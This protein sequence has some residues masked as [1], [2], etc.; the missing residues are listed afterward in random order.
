MSSSRIREPV[1]DTEISCFGEIMTAYLGGDERVQSAVF[2]DLLGETID[3]Y[4]CNDLFLT[5]LSAAHYGLVFSS[6]KARIDW[7][8]MGDVEMIEVCTTTVESVTVS[9]GDGYFLTVIASHG[10]VK[11]DFYDLV[12]GVVA[13]LREEAGLNN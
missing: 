13:L 2:Y 6:A 12:K 5:R 1:R 7:L 4:T 3:Y 10:A 8:K 9:V 11:G